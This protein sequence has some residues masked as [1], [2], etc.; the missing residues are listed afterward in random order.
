MV[1]VTVAAADTA[2][3][4]VV[5]DFNGFGRGGRSLWRSFYRR[6]KASKQSGCTDEKI[7]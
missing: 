6:M 5:M 4:A 1:A 7:K 2:V 3:A